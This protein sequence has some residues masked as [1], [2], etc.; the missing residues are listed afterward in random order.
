MINELRSTKIKGIAVF[1]VAATAVASYVLSN[2]TA[3]IIPIFILLIIL[4]IVVHSILGIPTM[5]NHYI[6]INTLSEVIDGRR[7]R[8]ENL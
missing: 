3:N 1:D 8:G 6:G 4:A 5:L 7:L 2:E